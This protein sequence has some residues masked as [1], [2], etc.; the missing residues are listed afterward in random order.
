MARYTHAIKKQNLC[1]CEREPRA[2]THQPTTSKGSRCRL[3]SL[4][5][6]CFQSG[7]CRCQSMQ[8]RH[9]HDV[10]IAPLHGDTNCKL[11]VNYGC[12]NGAKMWV[13][14]H[15]KAC[16]SAVGINCLQSISRL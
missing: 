3:L 1:A 10:P 15:A 5:R 4:P 12:L 7:G 14:A 9:Q 16:L 8:R 13:V 2:H 6:V 11:G